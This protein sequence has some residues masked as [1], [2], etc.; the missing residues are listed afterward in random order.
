M[1]DEPNGSGWENEKCNKGDE[2]I[3]SLC[4]RSGLCPTEG[5]TDEHLRHRVSNSVGK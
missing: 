2:D 4:V 5:S 1:C 3:K